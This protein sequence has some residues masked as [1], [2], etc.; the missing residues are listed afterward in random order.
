MVSKRAAKKT[1]SGTSLCSTVL[2]SQAYTIIQQE[3][4]TQ[5]HSDVQY[6]TYLPAF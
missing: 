5:I 1:K 3:F 2:A 4:K 6:F